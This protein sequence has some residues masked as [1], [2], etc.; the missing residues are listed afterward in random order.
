[1][2]LLLNVDTCSD[3]MMI[4]DDICKQDSEHMKL[5]QRFGRV[6]EDQCGTADAVE[7]DLQ[8]DAEPDGLEVTK[9][10]GF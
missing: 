7:R 9:S 10:K 4:L 1:M 2:R 5:K 6:E 3:V 8:N